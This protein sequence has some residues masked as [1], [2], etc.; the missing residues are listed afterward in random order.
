[1]LPA[2]RGSACYLFPPNVNCPL[3]GSMSFWQDVRV[4]IDGCIVVTDPWYWF[5]SV[6]EGWQIREEDI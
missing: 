4:Y 6:N 5:A 2:R 1:M 3:D